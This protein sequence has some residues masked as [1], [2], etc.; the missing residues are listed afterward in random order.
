MASR[1]SVDLK[2]KSCLTMLSFIVGELGDCCSILFFSVL[3]NVLKINS[4]LRVVDSIH[5]THV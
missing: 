5:P 3:L 1:L 4:P 2:R